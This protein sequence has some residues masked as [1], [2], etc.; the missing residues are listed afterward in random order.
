MLLQGVEKMSQVHGKTTAALLDLYPIL[1][2]LPDAFLPERRYAKH[3]HKESSELYVGHW[4]DVK[5]KIK[6]G[7][8]NS[9][10]C[11]DLARAQEEENFSDE[12]AGYISG[13]VLEAGADTT[14]AEII[15]C[16]YSIHPLG[17]LTDMPKSF[18]P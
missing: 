15:S 5:K 9:C 12:L 11:V 7:T 1:R 18:S 10:F 6:N 14:A 16:K 2:W 8:A 17:T 4:L 13:S 3:L